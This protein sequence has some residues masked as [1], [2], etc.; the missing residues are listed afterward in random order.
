VKI[1][2][3][4]PLSPPVIDV[5]YYATEA[6]VNGMLFAIELCRQMGASSAFADLRKREVLPGALGRRDM[7]ETLKKGATTYFHPTGTCKM[8]SDAE[9]V[10]DARL[11]VHG[12]A[13][14]RIA[15]ASIMPTVTRGNTNAPSVM[16]GERAAAFIT[17]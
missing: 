12:I 6:D 4:D 17:D 14:L 2:S 7:I 15:D 1:T 13:G 8:G 16:I 9:A 3:L 10:V 5:N 11:R